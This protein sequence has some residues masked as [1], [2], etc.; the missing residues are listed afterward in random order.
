MLQLK[1]RILGPNSVTDILEATN[2]V[3][4]H[5]TGG[6]ETTSGTLSWDASEGGGKVFNL[7][8]RAHTGWEVAKTFIVVISDIQGFPASVGSGESS[9]TTG[10]LN[11]TVRRF[12]Y[13]GDR[14]PMLQ[15]TEK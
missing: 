9:P 10:N 7:Y 8:V 5:S 3:Y 2:D 15:V 14:S 13:D 1:W 4:Y 11:L 6:Q 12:W